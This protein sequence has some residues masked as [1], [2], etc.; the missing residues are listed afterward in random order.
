MAMDHLIASGTFLID[1]LE[2]EGKVSL[3]HLPSSGLG[4]TRHIIMRIN[5]LVFEKLV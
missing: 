5:F 4:T 2:G 3:D 1:A